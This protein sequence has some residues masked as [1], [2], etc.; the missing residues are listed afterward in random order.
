MRLEDIDNDDDVDDD[1][2]DRY[3]RWPPWQG[4]PVQANPGWSCS[5]M[6]LF[7]K[8]IFVQL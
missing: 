5:C 8:L 2:N 6:S 3:H 1:D 4:M 7:D